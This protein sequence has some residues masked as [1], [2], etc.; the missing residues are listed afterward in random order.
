MND[1]SLNRNRRAV[2]HCCLPPPSP[3]GFDWGAMRNVVLCAGRFEVGLGFWVAC[4]GFGILYPL[5][6]SDP[7]GTSAVKAQRDMPVYQKKV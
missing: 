1:I 2:G 5:V 4:L 3:P 7:L 6:C